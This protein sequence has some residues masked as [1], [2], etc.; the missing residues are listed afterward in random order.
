MLIKIHQKFHSSR[1]IQEKQALSPIL[2]K[3]KNHGYK[4]SQI[5]TSIGEDAAALLPWLDSPN[6]ILITTDALLPSFIE[7]SPRGAGFSA[8]YV[9]VDDIMACGG[10]PIACS[11]TVAFGNSEIG[12]QIFQGILEG[13]RVFRVPLIRGHTTTDAKDLQLTSTIIG[14]CPRDNYISANGAHC[15]D[16]VALVWDTEGKPVKFNP[17]YWDTITMKTSET[18]YAKRGFFS[19]LLPLNLL[20]AC[21]DVSNG[22]IFGTLYQ[23]LSYSHKG[24]CIDLSAVPDQL[25]KD[26]IP[27]IIDDF[28]F[29]F[30]TSAFLITGATE[31]LEKIRGEVERS[32]M[33]FYN[34]GEI[35]ED[36]SITLKY[37]Q[38]ELILTTIDYVGE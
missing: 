13:T 5:H 8:I 4:S 10:T 19:A 17:M 2:T 32:G 36:K 28:L 16:F 37:Q 25:V 29:L 20:H 22:G 18:F 21:K 23:L 7:K 30:L 35:N 26:G 31:N 12:D 34:L 27:Y 6:F 3:I 1:N 14:S 33:K 15:K 11:T 9:G 24:A 38:E